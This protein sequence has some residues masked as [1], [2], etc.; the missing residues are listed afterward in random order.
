MV[1]SRENQ[2]IISFFII[3][4]TNSNISYDFVVCL[5]LVFCHMLKTSSEY[6]FLYF[7]RT[8]FICGITLLIIVYVLFRN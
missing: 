7:V 5:M 4:E 1:L 3:S 2:V 6:F 8:S